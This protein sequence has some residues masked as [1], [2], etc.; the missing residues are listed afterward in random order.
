MDDL[1]DDQ[2]LARAG[3]A[4]QILEDE[5]FKEAILVT[6]ERIIEAWKVASSSEVRESLH[7]QLHGLTSV[8]QA[9][10]GVLDDGDFL[11][12]QLEK[13]ERTGKMTERML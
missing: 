10:R 1:I 11:K 7:Y 8:V 3:R 2:I 9:I 12:D 6:E 13:K 5:L 4:K